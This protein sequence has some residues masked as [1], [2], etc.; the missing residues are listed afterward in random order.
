MATR[1][2]RDCVHARWQW[3]GCHPGGVSVFE[4]RTRHD[5]AQA[6]PPDCLWNGLGR[7]RSHWDPLAARADDTVPAA[8]CLP[9]RT[10]LRASAQRSTRQSRDRRLPSTLL[11]G[12]LH[13]RPTQV[14]NARAPLDHPCVDGDVGCR[15]VV[16]KRG[17]GG[18]RYR[19]VDP[20]PDAP[21]GERSFAGA[22]S[23]IGSSSQKQEP[24]RK[25]GMAVGRKQ[26][27]LSVVFLVSSLLAS[28]AIW[29][30][31]GANS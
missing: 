5:T 25:P 7:G 30:C 4:E 21:D 15:Y 31:V 12:T 14:R 18:R 19:C 16:G 10:K 3:R 29:G 27:K 26:E 8:G 9:L 1:S 22:F 24:L 13:E 23:W 20:H 28:S 2:S 11:R 17:A 6:I